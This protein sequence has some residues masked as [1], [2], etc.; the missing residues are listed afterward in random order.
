MPARRSMDMF[1]EALMAYARGDVSE[2][3]LRDHTGKLFKV[4]LHR[5]FRTASQFTRIERRLF[6]L[7]YGNILDIGCGTG[8]YFRLLSK[9][10]RVLGIDIS[11]TVIKAA[12]RC[13]KNSC[14]AADIFTF[15]SSRKFDTITLLGNG[16]GIAGTLKGTDRLLSRFQQL[17]KP[18]GQ[19]LAVGRRV[20]GREYYAV[21]MTSVWKGREGRRI[22]WINVG[23]ELLTR[24][25]ERHGFR[26]SVVC[27]NQHWLLYRLTK[28]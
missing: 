21:R 15:R 28:V 11:P 24:I 25:C 18:N 14:K 22:R 26:L 17:L 7:A 12:K 20:T 16:L 13:G 19:V 2:F 4:D 23:R 1:G 6:S 8:N 9:R 27:G 10:G 3:C 5:Y